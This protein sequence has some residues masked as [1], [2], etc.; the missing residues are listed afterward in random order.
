MKKTS[1]LVVAIATLM[2][3]CSPKM[4]DSSAG[5]TS[6]ETGMAAAYPRASEDQMGTDWVNNK[7]AGL[8]FIAT[9]NEPFWSVEIDFDSMMIYSTMADGE[10]LKTPVPA[11]ISPQ[12]VAA[13]N[14]RAEVESGALHVTIFPKTCTDDMSGIEYPYRVSVTVKEGDSG[15]FENFMGC[16]RFKGDYRLHDIWALTSIDGSDID[17]ADFPKGVPTMDLQIVNSKVYGLA[18]CNQYS[19]VANAQHQRITFG[20]LMSTKMA[21]PALRV[22]NQFM[23][24]IS[25]NSLQYELQGLQL[26]LS[27]DEHRLVFKK[28]D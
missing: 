24:A 4:N 1:F 5:N 26:I 22:E 25:G 14:Y 16:G 11:P 27:D 28:V 2:M 18:G 3:G 12:D 13:L 20:N 21:C 19:G 7:A 23:G 9:G 8:N 17:P 15:D 6:E 10:V